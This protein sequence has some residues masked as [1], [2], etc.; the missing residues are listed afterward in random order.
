[1]GVKNRERATGRPRP[2]HA[3]RH[4]SAVVSYSCVGAYE[5]DSL[6]S[7]A[8]SAQSRLLLRSSHPSTGLTVA[9]WNLATALVGPQGGLPVG[10][11][12]G[13]GVV[14]RRSRWIGRVGVGRGGAGSRAS[15]LLQRGDRP[16]CSL[17]STSY[18]ARDFADKVRSYG[19]GA[20]LFVGPRGTPSSCSRT[21]RHGVGHAG[22]QAGCGVWAAWVSLRSTPSYG[23][24]LPVRHGARGID[25]R[26]HK[27]PALSAAV[28]SADNPFRVMRPTYRHPLQL[29]LQLWLWLWLWL[30]IL[31]FS[32]GISAHSGVPLSGGRR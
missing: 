12:A 23:R 20:M 16:G 19:Q 1:V 3:I 8:L 9:G 5:N 15:S 14:F 26:A 28:A 10:S 7:H 32:R 2:P 11:F 29:Q 21:A 24:G 18:A 4:N 25:R 27:A 22:A 17:A 31:R 30:W 6:F 13:V